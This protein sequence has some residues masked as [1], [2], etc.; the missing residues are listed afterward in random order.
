MRELWAR[1]SGHST[2]SQRRWGKFPMV[3][4]LTYQ[5]NIFI[6]GKHHPASR[7]GGEGVSRSY[8]RR[9]GAKVERVDRQKQDQKNKGV[10]YVVCFIF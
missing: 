7:N 2:S 6:L 8:H 4:T 1:V 9:R 5:L 10:G 3:F